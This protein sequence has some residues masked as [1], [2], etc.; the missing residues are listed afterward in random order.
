MPYKV[1]LFF[2]TWLYHLRMP[3]IV[4]ALVF[5]IYSNGYFWFYTPYEDFTMAWRPDSRL[6]VIN[7]PKESVAND[8]LQSGD[9]LLSI[10]QQQIRRMSTLYPLP[11]KT[12]YEFTFM[13]NGQIA[14]TIIS[15]SSHITPLAIE[16]RLPP[17]ILSLI[18]T[19]LGA[20]ILLL[21][22]PKN[23]QALIAGYTFLLSASITTGIQS[24]LYGV[25]GAWFVGYTLI[26]F[27]LP[28]WSYLGLIPRTTSLHQRTK[29]LLIGETLIATTLAAAASY[30]VWFLY[31]KGLSFG[32]VT[33][34]SL[35]LSGFLLAACGIFS[36]FALLLWRVVWKNHAPYVQQQLKILLVFIALGIVPTVLLTILP[37]AFFDITLLPFPLAITLLMLVP[38]GFLFVI[39]RRGFLGLDRVFSQVIYL[40]IIALLILVVHSSGLLILQRRQSLSN[41]TFPST[42]MLLPTLLF[43]VYAN[44]PVHR[45]V[46]GLIYG[47]SAFSHGRVA[48][49]ALAFSTKPEAKTLTTIL[50]SLSLMIDVPSVALFLKNELSFFVPMAIY[51]VET[52]TSIDSRGMDYF[53]S[54]MIRTIENTPSAVVIFSQ[55]DWAEILVPV[56]LRNE[57][58]GI[59]VLSRPGGEGYFNARHV[60]FLRQFSGILAVGVE[61][62][63]LFESARKLSRQILVVQEDERRTLSLKIHDDPLHQIT[64]A[65]SVMDHILV[66][67]I[68]KDGPALEVKLQNIVEHLRQASESLRTLCIDLYSPFRF[69]GI[70]FA[71]DDIVR[72]FQEQ[73]GLKITLS[74]SLSEEIARDVSTRTITAVSR[75]LA[76]A[77]TNVVKHAECVEVSIEV[78]YKADR[79]LINIVITDNGLGTMVNDLSYT[80]LL[81]QGHLGLVGMYEWAQYVNGSL[82]LLPN[83]P[84]GLQVVLQCPLTGSE[85]LLEPRSFPQVMHP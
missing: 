6:I 17:T 76:G 7:V 13:R 5:V 33:G 42:I 48:E 1:P 27:M 69:H 16:L 78:F 2:N 70:R 25:P 50:E 56:T 4:L 51:G 54:P 46:D 66:K 43:V 24:A 36:C 75:I 29:I 35:Y 8:K 21:A 38:A 12:A 80:D 85:L 39:Y 18:S 68:G 63:L 20:G 65:I 40:I 83:E 10:D 67:G 49:F 28:L 57:L 32:E 23:E 45:F 74:F 72:R 26:F 62:I 81:R 61:N 58:V 3:G 9:I 64:Y 30:E 53:D 19:F 22:K 77:L 73:Y 55:F 60:S 15:F 34:V 31:P 79:N 14:S 41:T 82:Q 37:H 84:S 44:R 59:L 52:K 71:I 11:A 47:K